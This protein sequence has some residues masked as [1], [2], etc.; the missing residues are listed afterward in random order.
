LLIIVKLFGC[1][2]LSILVET[3]ISLQKFIAEL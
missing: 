3:A 2:L 1:E